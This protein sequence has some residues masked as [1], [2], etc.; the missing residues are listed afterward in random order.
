L[1]GG[2]IFVWFRLVTLAR[3]REAR[4]I[5]E[6]LADEVKAGVMSADEV[7]AISDPQKRMATR[8]AALEESVH[9]PAHERLR[10][11]ALATE[12]AFAKHK[13]KIDAARTYA[14]RIDD[15]RLEIARVRVKRR[16]AGWITG[17]S[18]G[19]ATVSNEPVRQ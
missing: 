8:T 14:A 17:D 1:A 4:W 13:A 7:A 10:L 2:A 12:L 15:L 3:A 16:A 19:L 6:E 18:K 5:K 9:G 11:Y